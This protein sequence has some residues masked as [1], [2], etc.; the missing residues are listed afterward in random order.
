MVMHSPRVWALWGGAAVVAVV[1]A[2]TV[3]GDL[4][5]LH[6]RAETLGSERRVVVARRPLRLGDTV[7]R[8]DLAR[9]R[10]HRSQLPPGALDTTHAVGRVVAVP[11]VRGGFVAD[12]NLAPRA[13][14]GLDGVLPSG[15]RVI[16]VVL[17][18]A[19]RPR[20]GAAVDVLATF[21]TPDEITGSADV[22]ARGVIVLGVVRVTSA[23]GGTGLAVN[24]LV[25]E[26]DAEALAFAA[27]HG[28][29]TLVLV[30]PEDARLP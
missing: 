6:R 24:L 25:T 10:V 18:H 11:V 28:E 23:E 21:A 5:E 26:T 30:P 27:S 20:V 9:R 16:Q 3:A 29:L 1:T 14:T 22:V 8:G 15:T 19:P 12:A 7:R 13:R 17:D 2:T 4:A